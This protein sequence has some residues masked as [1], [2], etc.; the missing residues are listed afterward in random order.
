MELG[1]GGRTAIVCGAS[2]GIGLGCAEALAGEGANV[3][4]LARGAEALEREAAR[5]GATALPGDVTVLDDLERLVATAVELHGGAIG[6]A[7][8]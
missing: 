4:M 2:A 3:V 7:H 1:L 5:L 6:R 8:V